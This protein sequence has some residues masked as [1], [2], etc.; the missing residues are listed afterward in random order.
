M[1]KFLYLFIIA[2]MPLFTMAQ[3][4]QE[5]WQPV[6]SWPFTMKEFTQATITTAQGQVIKV[7]ANIHVGSHYVWYENGS[8]KKLEAKKGT[9]SKITFKNGKTYYAIND[10]MCSV[11]SED[12]ID[13]KLCRL[14][15]SEELNRDEYNEMARN[16]RAAMVDLLDAGMALS[17]LSNGVAENEGAKRLEDSPLPIRNFFY[18]LY[19]GEVFPATETNIL[20]QMPTKQE[21]NAYRS[22]TRKAEIQYSSKKSMLTVWNTF[23]VNKNKNNN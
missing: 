2:C 18:I 12:T 5:E 17:A 16:N 10:K 1:M 15:I 22:F 8:K 7:N 20:K 6:A 19:N 14:Y 3:Q 4:E 11:L 23:F 13:G 21:R 9:I